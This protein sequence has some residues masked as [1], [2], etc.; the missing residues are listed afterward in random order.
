MALVEFHDSLRIPDYPLS[1]HLHAFSRCPARPAA[2]VYEVY[3]LSLS[4][5]SY[6][7]ASR[8]LPGDV[9]PQADE[10]YAPHRAHVVIFLDA[11]VFQK[12]VQFP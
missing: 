3:W 7:L 8:Q 10:L 12:I 5:P 6:L 2:A 4:T 9:I 1:H 11:K